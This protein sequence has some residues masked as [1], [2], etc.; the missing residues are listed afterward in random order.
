MTAEPIGDSRPSIGQAEVEFLGNLALLDDTLLQYEYVLNFASDI[1]EL[2]EAACTDER[3]VAGCASNAWMALT[4]EDGCLGL[5]LNA[6]ALI[7][8]GLLGV[9]TWLLDGRS[10]PEVAAWEPRLLDDPNLKPLLN[11]DRRHG[12]ASIVAAIIG[13]CQR[14]V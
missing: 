12:I 5:R 9:L 13:F 3:K 10:L 14:A 2:P 8:K 7:I 1:D 11:T 4:C 6:D